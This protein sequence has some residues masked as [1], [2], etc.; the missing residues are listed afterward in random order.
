[1]KFVVDS[2]S[3]IRALFRWDGIALQQTEREELANLMRFLVIYRRFAL[4]LTITKRD[5]PDFEISP[6]Q[7]A[8]NIGLGP[9]QIRCR[10]YRRAGE[11]FECPMRFSSGTAGE[12]GRYRN[13]EQATKGLKSPHAGY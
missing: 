9:R 8:V 3:T 6:N 4:P 5:R 12:R 10:R 1:M 7:E 2:W 13:A 11:G